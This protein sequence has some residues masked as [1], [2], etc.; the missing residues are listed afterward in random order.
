MFE[1]LIDYRVK[2]INEIYNDIVN[3]VNGLR[4]NFPGLVIGTWSVALSHEGGLEFLRTW[5]GQDAADMVKKVKPDVH[6]FQTH[7]PD[8]VMPDL[9]PDYAKKYKPYI[10][11][12][13]KV[14]PDIAIGLQG[15]I[16]SHDNMR[17]SPKW[18]EDFV[19]YSGEAGLDATTIYEYLLRWEVYHAAPC[20]K[21]SFLVEKNKIDLI[22]DQP[23]DPESAKKLSG[24]K[25]T[26]FASGKTYD[27][28][29]LE[30][31][32]NILTL[33]VEGAPEPG[34]ILS[35]PVGGITDKPLLRFPKN[36]RA[37]APEEKYGKINT[38]P[39]GTF[40]FCELEKGRY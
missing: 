40:A 28:K 34:K 11:S 35:Y 18:Y 9:P 4:E 27:I 1:E 17:K 15:D 32:G 25:I 39:E 3:G 23:I 22:F 2:V 16:G 31:D 12:L 30:T 10:D 8:W 38:I 24:K 20:L 37:T 19:K 7:W 6:F 36:P 14:A 26:D 13:K 5:E 21:K 33:S 29:G